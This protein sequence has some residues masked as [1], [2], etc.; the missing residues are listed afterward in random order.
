MKLTIVIIKFLFLGALF[1][2]S[3]NNLA[4]RD[5]HN[6]EQFFDIYYS[7]LSQVFDNALTLT[8][9]VVKFEWLPT[10]ENFT[11]VEVQKNTNFVP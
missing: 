1:I 2:I 6:R 10:A 3:N 11:V 4:L 9:Y 5:S 7:W 8:S